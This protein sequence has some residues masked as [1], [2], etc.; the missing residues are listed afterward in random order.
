M[1]K[2]SSARIIEDV[3]M[4]LK[5][6]EMVYRTNGAAVE[7]IADKNGHRGKVFGEGKSVSWAGAQTKSKGRE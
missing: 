2:H 3:D 6:L 4:A 1:G 5:A 7:G